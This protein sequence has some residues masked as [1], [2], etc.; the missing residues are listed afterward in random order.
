[1]GGQRRAFASSIVLIALFFAGCAS[2]EDV[3]PFH[4]DLESADWSPG[5]SW[6]WS[7]SSKTPFFGTVNGW[8]TKTVVEGE[9][10]RFEEPVHWLWLEDGEDYYALHSSLY[11]PVM[12]GSEL[13]A[14]AASDLRVLGAHDPVRPTDCEDDPLWFEVLPRGSEFAF[15]LPM[16][17]SEAPQIDGGESGLTSRVDAQSVTVP[18]G[19]FDAVRVRS[20]WEWEGA[21]DEWTVW[22]A[23]EVENVA[24][25]DHRAIS[26]S[27]S[28]STA[29]Y[30]MESFSFEER[31]LQAPEIRTLADRLAEKSAAD[32]LEGVA[33]ATE[34]SSPMNTAGSE[35]V[36]VT[37]GLRHVPG[38]SS[39]RLV[40]VPSLDGL[41]V[42]E[43]DET[44][45]WSLSKDRKEVA[46]AEGMTVT[47]PFDNA[48]FY[49]IDVQVP[50]E[51]GFPFCDDDP[52]DLMFPE[53]SGMF[54]TKW[55]ETYDVRVLPGVNGR[56]E[57]GSFEVLP[58]GPRIT[59]VANV[60]FATE[61][62]HDKPRVV[63]VAPDGTEEASFHRDEHVVFSPIAGTWR[64][65]WES[66]GTE[67]APFTYSPIVTGHEAKVT[68]THGY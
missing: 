8:F 61:D 30:L 41:D 65:F 55:E 11:V 48:G 5:Y 46:T 12:P 9:D 2:D 52:D 44:P 50:G 66:R 36:E 42:P 59:T 62:H 28:V 29:S 32:R 33:I 37:F 63:L 64:I 6:T 47:F 45:L 40:S 7:T 57:L 15:S 10:D 43:L 31:V 35:D 25:A 56:S 22:Y 20:V 68:V 13:Q 21:R 19:T 23:P 27:G 67:L 58:G 26:R 60:S 4:G 39:H 18:A 14:L 24:K 1:M 53:F 34:A 54:F 16:A 3:R 49:E 51:R 17:G 38:A